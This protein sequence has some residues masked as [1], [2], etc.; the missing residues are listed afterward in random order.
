MQQIQYLGLD[1]HKAII[2]AIVL[3]AR[4]ELVLRSD[5]PTREASVLTFI[6][7]L[8]GTVHVAFEEGT[9]AQWLFDLL[10]PL[11]ASVTVCRGV[12]KSRSRN[13]SDFADA[14]ELAR[15]LRLGDLQPVFHR[16]SSNLRTLRH[17]VRSYDTLVADSVRTML[18]LG[19]L[20][21]GVA[22]PAQ[23][24]SLYNPTRRDEWI[25]RLPQPG[26][27]LRAGF[28][29]DLLA[30]Q[31]AVRAQ[32][33]RQMLAEARRHPAW[34]LL[35]SHPLVGPIRA[36]SLIASIGSPFRFR[37]KR[38]LWS[39]AGFAI[40]TESSG[41]FDLVDGRVVRKRPPMTRGLTRSFNRHL[42]RLFKS[43]ACDL[44]ARPGP[45]RDWY[46]ARLAHGMRPDMARLALARKLAAVILTTWKKGEPFDSERLI[47]DS[48]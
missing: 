17:L 11:V 32:A 48:H 33:H 8:P 39:Y 13:K 43:L 15:L 25:A 28:L 10:E 3:D 41:E 47:R 35:T 23:S 20:F 7:S 16:Y 1:V 2:V 45:Y 22:V 30:T 19:A 42:K 18:R 12:P 4:G 38:Q 31:R 26:L 37:S 27:R 36:A 46:Q 44:A 9:Q 24:R 14:F 34:P 5:V 6:E 29:Y 40:H 21:R